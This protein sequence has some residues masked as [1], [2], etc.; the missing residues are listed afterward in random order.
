ME[1]RSVRGWRAFSMSLA[2]SWIPGLPSHGQCQACGDL[3]W[4]LLAWRV[5]DDPSL[6][7]LI[8]GLFL[9]NRLCWVLREILWKA[10]NFQYIH[11]TRNCLWLGHQSLYNQLGPRYQ[12]WFHS[13]NTL[14]TLYR[15]EQVWATVFRKGCWEYGTHWVLRKL[16][17]L[18]SQN[19]WY[20][21][22]TYCQSS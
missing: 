11:P 13:G 22:T 9:S 6:C 17:S 8:I 5:T 16:F 18:L 7:E 19:V 12:D 3:G 10:V 14:A 15:K 2:I 1:V 20:Y 4:Q 21:L